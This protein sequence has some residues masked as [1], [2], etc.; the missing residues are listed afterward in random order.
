[1]S[2][3]PPP[4]PAVKQL[5]AVIKQEIAVGIERLE[6]AIKPQLEAAIKQQEREEAIEQQERRDAIKRKKHEAANKQQEREAVIKQRREDAAEQRRQAFQLRAVKNYTDWSKWLVTLQPATMALLTWLA[7]HPE[8][9]SLVW[10]QK[11][12]VYFAIFSFGISTLA[13]SFILGG[14]PSIVQ[15]IPTDKIADIHKASIYHQLTLW[16]VGCAQHVGFGLGLFFFAAF[17][18]S[19]ILS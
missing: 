12:S 16:H 7:K 1:M 6:A 13:A 14:A 15:R 8:H 2:N 10:R 17:L 4:E 3:E 5:E 9:G 11:A 18:C 19:L